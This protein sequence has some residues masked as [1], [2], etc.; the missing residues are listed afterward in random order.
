MVQLETTSQI[1]YTSTTYTVQSP[2]LAA[3]VVMRLLKLQLVKRVAVEGC[4]G[5]LLRAVNLLRQMSI[6]R[7]DYPAR[8]AA[9]LTKLWKDDSTVESSVGMGMLNLRIRSRGL[10]G[11]AFD[12]LWKYKELSKA[13]LSHGSIQENT[14]SESRSSSTSDIG[15]TLTKAD[16]LQN[17]VADF[18]LHTDAPSDLFGPSW[19]DFMLLG[20][21]WDLQLPEIVTNDLFD[22]E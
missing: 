20:F 12:F 1:T 19:D 21:D 18:T 7:D 2:F 16:Q 10:C 17:S 4:E 9:I 15:L 5:V 13:R 6:I 3:C 14:N 22:L 8:G 11:P